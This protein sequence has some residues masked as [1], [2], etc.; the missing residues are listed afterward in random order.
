[1]IPCFQTTTKDL[2]AACATPHLT[3]LNDSDTTFTKDVQAIV[4]PLPDPLVDQIMS[5]PPAD[6]AISHTEAQP[7]GERRAVAMPK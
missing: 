3:L 7:E 4:V 1:M 6:K 2:I 5:G